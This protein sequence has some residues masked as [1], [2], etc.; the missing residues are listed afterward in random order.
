MLRPTC[1]IAETTNHTVQCDI[2]VLTC[3]YVESG[4]LFHSIKVNNM[5]WYSALHGSVK[6]ICGDDCHDTISCD[7]SNVL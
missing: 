5:P 1:V 7:S 4:I 3:D 2:S 6:C